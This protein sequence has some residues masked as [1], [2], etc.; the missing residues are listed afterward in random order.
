MFDACISLIE[1]KDFQEITINE[2][3][4]KVDINRGTFYLRFEDKYE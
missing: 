4:E 2:I 1:E 3:V